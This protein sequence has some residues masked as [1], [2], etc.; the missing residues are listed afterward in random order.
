MGGQNRSRGT[1]TTAARSVKVS[2]DRGAFSKRVLLSPV[3]S[4][5]EL[6]CPDRGSARCLGG[7][8]TA[9]LRGAARS[10]WPKLKSAGHSIQFHDFS[11]YP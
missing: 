11:R 10:I 3:S 4:P 1:W 5:R 9:V 7:Q 6:D 8:L 2:S